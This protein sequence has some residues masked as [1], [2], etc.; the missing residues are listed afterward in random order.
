M[1]QNIVS[2]WR[3]HPDKPAFL[4]WKNETEYKGQLLA[5]WIKAT[6]YP[7]FFEPEGYRPVSW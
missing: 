2:W 3:M 1:H 7:W 4:A 6:G 5:G